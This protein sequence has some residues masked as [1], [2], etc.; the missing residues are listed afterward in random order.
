[1]EAKL[2]ASARMIGFF[3]VA[4][5]LGQMCAT[6]IW[7]QFAD[8]WK[9]LGFHRESLLVASSFLNGACCLLFSCLDSTWALLVVRFLWGCCSGDGG[10]VQ[11]YLAHSSTSRTLPLAMTLFAVFGLVGA[12]G[13]PLATGKF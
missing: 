11:D 2:H 13:S 8:K 5:S 1:M 4:F 7:G 12:E 9:E 6:P 3:T 10:M